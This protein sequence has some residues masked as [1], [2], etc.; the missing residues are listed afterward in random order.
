MLKLYAV[1]LSASTVLTVCF[2]M[3]VLFVHAFV[4]IGSV[5]PTPDP[6]IGYKWIV[7]EFQNIHL[8]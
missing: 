3:V 4:A 6:Y 2:N 5:F 1:L 7:C 8:I